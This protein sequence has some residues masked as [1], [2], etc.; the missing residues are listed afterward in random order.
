VED[1]A[2][3]RAAGERR[4]TSWWSWDDRPRGG[5]LQEGD[6]DPEAREYHLYVQ[7]LADA[8]VRRLADRARGKGP[9]LY[10]DLPLG[11]NPDSYDVWRDR[12]SFALGVSAGAPPDVFFTKGQ[13]WGF[14]PLHPDNIRADGYRY[15]R[16]CLHHHLRYAGMLRIDHMM[17]LHRFF[18]VPQGLGPKQGVYVRYP[19]EELYAVYCLESNRHQ[20]V[21]VGEDLGTV[22]NNVRPTMASHNIHRL[23][24]GQFEMQPN[25]ECALNPPA[26]GAVASLNTHDTPTFAGFWRGIDIE[27]CQAMGLFDEAGARSEQ[28]RRSAIRDAVIGYLRR[29]GLLG[30][31]ADIPAVL[32]ACLEHIA[33]GPVQVVL[34]TIEDLWQATEP[35]NVPGTWHEKPNWRR[36]A[37]HPLEAFDHVPG[38]R[39][40]LLALHKAIQE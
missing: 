5:D 30:R 17:G 28:Q 16:D 1:Y 11:V 3:F 25:W 10:L 7:W 15:L 9:G 23:Y 8:Q 31:D 35:Q 26:E 18:W 29:R 37:L 14:P 20:T 33:R 22:P 21:M 24:V 34:A 38:L 39:D 40:T 36:K 32:R 4:R 12:A 13:E 27:E 19:A 6:Y 2:A